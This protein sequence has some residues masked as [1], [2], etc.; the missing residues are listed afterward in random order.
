LTSH[1]ITLD[2][3]EAKSMAGDV[4][5]PEVV[6]RENA[7]HYR[8]GHECDGWHLVKDTELSVIEELMPSGAA[9][10]LHHH[11]RAQQFFF[12][13]VGE[14]LMEADGEMTLVPAGSG[15]RVLPGTKHL[16][17]NPAAT[18]AR[19]LVISQPPSHKDRINE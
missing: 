14:L 16:I 8:W 3:E 1:K 4:A 15:I 2:S 11:E 12:V 18:A 9:E 17:R 19:F 10:V 13:L 5:R 7:E 6:N